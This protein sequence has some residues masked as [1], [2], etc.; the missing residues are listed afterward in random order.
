MLDRRTFL[1][2]S[3]LAGLMAFL[4]SRV[5]PQQ[6]K[7]VIVV[8]AGLAGLTAGF[9]LMQ[10]GHEVDVVSPSLRVPER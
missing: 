10:S 3:T 4:L 5:L 2:S 1:K 7:K 9:E 6:P 8:G